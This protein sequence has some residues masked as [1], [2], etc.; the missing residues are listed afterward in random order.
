M[1]HVRLEMEPYVVPKHVTVLCA[2]TDGARQYG[3]Y[4]LIRVIYNIRWI[5]SEWNYKWLLGKH[6][7]DR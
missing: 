2:T 7:S 5:D 1:H 6:V 4:L 3:E